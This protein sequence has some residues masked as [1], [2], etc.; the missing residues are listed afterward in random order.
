MNTNCKAL[1]SVA[2]IC[3][4]AGCGAEA[5]EGWLCSV[6][7]SCLPRWFRRQIETPMETREAAEAGLAAFRERTR[8]LMRF[9]H[10]AQ[11]N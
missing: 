11:H 5:C 2:G 7:W 8:Q 3:Q 4:V 9:A 1:G 6:H 10:H